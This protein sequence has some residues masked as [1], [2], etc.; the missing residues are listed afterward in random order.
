ML[1]HPIKL[2]VGLGNPE[3]CHE[4]TLHNAGFWFADELARR[5]SVKFHYEKN[6][7]F[8][9]G[10]VPGPNNAIITIHR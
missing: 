2:I 5:A 9:K 7:L 8:V 6:Q 3:E 4:R 1:D 10:S